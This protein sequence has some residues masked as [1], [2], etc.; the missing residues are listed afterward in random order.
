MSQLLYRTLLAVLPLIVMGAVSAHAN[1]NLIVTVTGVR[2]ADGQIAIMAF[3][4]QENFDAE[5]P[6]ARFKFPK[7]AL[8]GDTQWA[9]SPEQPLQSHPAQHTPTTT[10]LL[11][12]AQSQLSKRTQL[13]LPTMHP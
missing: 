11:W 8:D 13:S 4:N 2:A 9:L 6:V 1:E 3:D 10:L 7:T 12:T 5:K